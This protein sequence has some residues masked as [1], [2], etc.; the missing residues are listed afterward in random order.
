MK[1]VNVS[2]SLNKCKIFKKKKR[3]NSVID[4]ATLLEWLLLPAAT[5][6]SL[7]DLK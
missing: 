7:R 3:K 1:M 2:V 5:D 4:F 6:N